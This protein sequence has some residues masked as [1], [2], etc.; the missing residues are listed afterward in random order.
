ME[1]LRTTLRRGRNVWD[2]INMPEGEFEARVEELRRIMAEGQVDVALLYGDAW[3][4][5][6]NVCYVSNYY[7]IMGG[8]ICVVPQ[9]G[10]VALI[11]WGSGRGIQYTEEVTW[12][13]RLIP[14]PDIVAACARHLDELGLSSATVGLVG[15]GE[16]MPH[17]ELQAFYGLIGGCK[18]VD[19]GRAVREMRAVKSAKE[20]D[21]VHRASRLLAESFDVVA[22][23]PFL[24]ETEVALGAA[25]DRRARLEGGEDARILVAKPQQEEWAFRPCEDVRLSNG[26]TVAIYSAAEFERY[27]AEMVRTFAIGENG[28][29]P[30]VNPELD[31]LYEQVVG[32]IVPG[33]PI[34]KFCREVDVL[35]AK[36]GYGFVPHYGLGHG[37]GMS[38]NEAPTIDAGN[39][40]V[41][42]VGMCLSLHMAGGDVQ[43][44][45][46][47]IGNSL[48]VS[49]EGTKI[50]TVDVG[51]ENS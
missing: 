19:F 6:A 22:G 12:V 51:R 10:E 46:A 45:G 17:Q 28:I 33:K 5:Y 23:L 13:K 49:E 42:E 26:E 7:P 25:L 40:E 48:V 27:W 47:V 36:G 29:V 35:L 8:S 1:V 39:E 41:F 30:V 32:L 2:R 9:N 21:Q 34:S 14:S 38:V 37:I 4:D 3:K 24:G 15:F 16:L 11:F 43:E 44:V 31:S 50:L 18:I 20:R